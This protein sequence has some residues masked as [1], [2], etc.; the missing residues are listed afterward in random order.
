MK[1]N[2]FC[3]CVLNNETTVI[4][5]EEERVHSSRVNQWSLCSV[6]RRPVGIVV[7]SSV[8][9]YAYDINGEVVPLEYYLEQF[10]G[11]REIIEDNTFNQTNYAP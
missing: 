6:I 10:N 1:N 7:K 5:L 9:I 11:L 3:T 8:G 4:T 2:S